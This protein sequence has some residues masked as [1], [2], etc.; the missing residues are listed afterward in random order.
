MGVAGEQ[1]ATLPHKQQASFSKEL[2]ELE[3]V[4]ENSGRLS[5]LEREAEELQAM[6]TSTA[7]QEIRQLAVQELEELQDQVNYKLLREGVQKCTRHY[8]VY[9]IIRLSWLQGCWNA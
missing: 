8:Q 6:A 9:V 7:E 4:L 2:G 5:K 1:A 3:S